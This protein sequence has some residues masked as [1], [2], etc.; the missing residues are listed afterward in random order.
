MGFD[1]NKDLYDKYIIPILIRNIKDFE[2]NK[3]LMMNYILVII[4]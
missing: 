4:K 1:I 2:N 3:N